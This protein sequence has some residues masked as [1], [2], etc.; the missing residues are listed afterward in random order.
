MKQTMKLALACAAIAACSAAPAAAQ[1]TWE[2]SITPYL[3]APNMDGDAAIGPLDF[4]V[5]SDPSDVFSNLNWGF[6]GISEAN[7]GRIG[8]ALD[9]TYMNLKD[10]RDGILD[11]VGGHQGAYTGMVLA[12]LGEHVE[13]YVGARV[14]D[15]GVRIQ[16]TGPGG[17]TTV[18]ARGKSWVD[19]LVGVRATLPLGE[20]T[21]LT[22]LADAGGFG[23]SS[24]IALQFWPTVGFR[25]SDNAR[26]QVGYRLAYTDYQSG[27]GLSRFKYDVLTFGP[28]VGVK[29]SF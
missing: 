1:D 6:M 2:Y 11:N 14:N 3:M 26:A 24:D 29:F 8:V 18:A 20:T 22:V 27:T 15:L 10:K 25:L 5:S 28:T 21:D 7:N 17:N 16:A 23:V 12:R 19:P 13:G 4:G 9:V